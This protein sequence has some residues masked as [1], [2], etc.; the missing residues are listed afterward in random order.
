MEVSELTSLH[1]ALMK[2]ISAAR[3]AAEE[4]SKA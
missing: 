1:A 4:P 2:V 3:D